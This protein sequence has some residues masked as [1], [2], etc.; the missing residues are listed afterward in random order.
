MSTLKL[1]L[2]TGLFGLVI[3]SCK[4]PAGEGGKSS[5]KGKIWVEDWDANFVTI[6]YQYAGYDEDV[7]IIYGDDTSYGDR[8]RANQ[9]GVFEFKHL[10]AGKYKVYVYSKQPQ[11]VANPADKKAIIVDI[12]LGKKDDKDAGTFTIKK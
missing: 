10:R 8:I 12:E 6:N 4:K 7:Y 2:I 9:E 1:I 11:T 3:A 5:I